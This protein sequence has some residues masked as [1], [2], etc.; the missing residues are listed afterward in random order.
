[1]PIF[2]IFPHFNFY[3]IPIFKFKLELLDSMLEIDADEQYRRR[4]LVC[5]AP[6]CPTTHATASVP[7]APFEQR[8]CMEGVRIHCSACSAR[9]A[10]CDC[11][12]ALVW[13][14][15]PA[16]DRPKS[17]AAMPV[18]GGLKRKRSIACSE[19]AA[20][21]S[22]P[23]PPT[24][25]ALGA[26]ARTATSSGNNSHKKQNFESLGRDSKHNKAHF[27][28]TGSQVETPADMPKDVGATSFA[29]ETSKFTRQ[30]FHCGFHNTCHSGI[31]T[32][33]NLRPRF[34]YF[35][36]TT[37]RVLQR[38][39]P[40][41]TAIAYHA[42]ELGKLNQALEKVRADFE[43]ESRSVDSGDRNSNNLSLSDDGSED[44]SARPGQPKIPAVGKQLPQPGKYAS[45]RRNSRN[46]LTHI[47]WAYHRDS[48]SSLSGSSQHLA[49]L[50][51]AIFRARSMLVF[52]PHLSVYRCHM[53]KALF[54]MLACVLQ[55]SSSIRATFSEVVLELLSTYLARRAGLR[56]ARDEI[57]AL[58][59][60]AGL[61]A[62]ED[63]RM[64]CDSE[65][66]G[67][68][69]RPLAM[70][71]GLKLHARE[72]Q[73]KLLSAEKQFASAAAAFEPTKRK[74]IHVLD[75]LRLAWRE[76][77][78]Q[79]AKEQNSLKFEAIGSHKNEAGNLCYTRSKKIFLS[80][81]GV[82]K[83]AA[84]TGEFEA[85]SRDSQRRISGMMQGSTSEV[86]IGWGRRG[87]ALGM[88]TPKISNTRAGANGV[89]STIPDSAV[90]KA[91]IEASVL[92]SAKR[93]NP[94]SNV[95]EHTM[96]PPAPIQPLVH[97]EAEGVLVEAMKFCRCAYFDLVACTIL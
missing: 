61:W 47:Q 40:R 48:L 67:E 54:P 96:T 25:V 29:R 18:A 83:S 32:A 13:D 34:A 19:A 90:S 12:G 55:L 50:D 71:P 14:L 63:T 7:L 92:P 6:H 94:S 73:A 28:A 69:T 1:M 49:K 95:S 88:K 4:R 82:I 74:L 38:A 39:A 76:T 8:V 75:G 78:H 85:S 80:S 86:P 15:P 51:A 10:L 84:E 79:G 46:P 70:L 97:N 72:S 37:A 17:P 56:A 5:P 65:N 42:A 89:A 58:R 64:H 2:L 59:K 45:R 24:N 21:S 44:S 3:H 66:M 60:A 31:R 9:L 23:Y 41:P 20:D 22:L 87:M 30:C 35:G 53:A 57:A 93:K 91:S 36:A 52:K 77:V 27:Q 16:T 81:P 62:V 26:A 43:N 68:V 11:C 33:L